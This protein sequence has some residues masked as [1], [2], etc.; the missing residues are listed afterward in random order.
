MLELN[1]HD[2]AKHT[3]EGTVLVD[4]YATWCG[5]CRAIAPMLEQLKDVKVVK[6]NTEDSPELAVKF[7]VSHLPTL[8]FMKDGVEVDRKIGL[9]GLAPT[10]Q[11]IDE[12]NANA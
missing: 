4:F 1:E 10:Q 8:V 5:P 9:Q 2:F 12:I 3:S 6:V 11:R 7:R